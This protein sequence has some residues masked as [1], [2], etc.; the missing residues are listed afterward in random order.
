[1]SETETIFFKKPDKEV[2]IRINT[3]MTLSMKQKIEALQKEFPQKDITLAECLRIGCGVLLSEFGDEDYNSS[4]N[5]LRKNQAL[6]QKWEDAKK[7]LED[8]EKTM[9]L[10]K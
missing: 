4:I 9:E 2:K 8:I 7:E 5:I 10:K 1:M 3:T 6:V